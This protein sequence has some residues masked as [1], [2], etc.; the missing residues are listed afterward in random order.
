MKDKRVLL[1]I[2]CYLQAGI[3]DGGLV[4]PRTEGTPHVIGDAPDQV[5]DP[6]ELSLLHVSD[7]SYRRLDIL[8]A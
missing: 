4:S 2:R 3:M 8:S 5:R 6:L 1:S 7:A